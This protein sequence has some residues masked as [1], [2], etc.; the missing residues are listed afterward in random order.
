[1][2]AIVEIQCI[3]TDYST[4]TQTTLTHWINTTLT[5][6]LYQASFSPELTVRIVDEAESEALN[7]QWRHCSKPTNVLS[8][9][10]EQTPSLDVL[11]LG[12]IV[13]CAPLI[14]QEAHA[15]KKPVEA[16]WAHLIV[17]GT[18]HLLGYDHLEDKQAHI[19]EDLE[20]TILHR[21]GYANPY[22]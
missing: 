6:A 2:D 12:D 21:L 19:M 1:M 3:C 7:K 9:P 16:H 13:V 14:I 15:Q 22:I 18:L 17:H 4:P 10:F 8:F 5:I 20:I 11:L